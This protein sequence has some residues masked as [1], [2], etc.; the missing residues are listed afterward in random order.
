M[1]YL[2]EGDGEFGVHLSCDPDAGV[3][4]DILSLCNCV[5]QLIHEIQ[6]KMT[7]L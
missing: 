4:V 1:P 5:Q 7:V 3:L 2:E 6:T